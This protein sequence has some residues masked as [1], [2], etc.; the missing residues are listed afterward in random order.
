[1]VHNEVMFDLDDEVRWWRIGGFW[2]GALVTYRE[3]QLAAEGPFT[4]PA[5]MCEDAGRTDE[6]NPDLGEFMMGVWACAGWWD[7][8]DD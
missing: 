3:G 8:A 5:R 7:R 6:M 4:N 1:M 2:C